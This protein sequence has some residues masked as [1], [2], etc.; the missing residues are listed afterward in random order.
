MSELEKMSIPVLLPIIHGTPV[1]LSLPEQVIVATWFFKTA[2]MYD[3]HSER[4]APRP[5]YFEDYEHRQL[6]DTLSMNPFYA[7]Y[8]GKYTG[9]Q[10]F[11]IQEDHSDLVFAKR[12]DL[13]PLG[14]SV[15]VYSLTLAIKHL[16]LQIFCAKTTLLST[17]PLYAR[18]WSAFYVQL[19]TLPFR[20]DWPPPLN[21]DDSLIEHFIH[22]WSD[23]PSLPPT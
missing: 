15:R 20:V 8:L 6:R 2:V 12:S 18:D 5:L 14:D 21:L 4:Q 23:I 3:L 22:R 1:T 10:F 13:Q 9:E 11:I 16:V 7:I 19:A 17:V